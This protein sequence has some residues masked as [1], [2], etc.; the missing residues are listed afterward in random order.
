MKQERDPP[1]PF[2]ASPSLCPLLPARRSPLRDRRCGFLDCLLISSLPPSHEGEGGGGRGGHAPSCRLARGMEREAAGQRPSLFDV[3]GLLHCGFGAGLGLR[4]RLVDGHRS[5]ERGG[6]VLPRV[7]RDALELWDRDELH[8][9]IGHR[10]HRRM[11]RIGRVDRTRA[12]DPPTAPP[13]YSRGSCRAR[14]GFRAGRGPSRP[15][16]RRGR[17]SA[18]WSP[19]K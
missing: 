6:E 10:L 19:M 7:S 8:A 11:V 4:K 5:R 1:S 9:G 2:A 16:R 14:C 12:S 17:C 15:L 3:A 18:C 13:S